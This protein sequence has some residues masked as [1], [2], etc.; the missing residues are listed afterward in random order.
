MSSRAPADPVESAALIARGVLR[1]ARRLRAARSPEAVSLS[2]FG[3]LTTL[4]RLGP[5]PAV[6]LAHEEGL[7]PQSLTRLM[8]SLETEGLI[9]RRRDESDRRAVMVDIT[10]EGRRAVARDMAARRAWLEQAMALALNPAE[11][12]QLA[13]AAQLMLKVAEQAVDELPLGPD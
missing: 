9:R 4:I 7:Q 12:A 2:A 8:A 6:R 11:H 13:Q 3:L 5:M 10:G 1:L